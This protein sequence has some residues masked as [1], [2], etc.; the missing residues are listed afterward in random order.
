MNKI[1]VPAHDKGAKSISYAPGN[2]I[3]SWRLRVTAGA[4]HHQEEARIWEGYEID[5]NATKCYKNATQLKFWDIREHYKYYIQE[6][7]KGYENAT[8]CTKCVRKVWGS[9]RQKGIQVSLAFNGTRSRQVAENLFPWRREHRGACIGSL[10][11]GSST[12]LKTEQH[13]IPTSLFSDTFDSQ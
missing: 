12:S 5:E 4:K 7:Y 9:T 3:D 2:N 11:I 8:R 6:R 10:T 13:L 1:K